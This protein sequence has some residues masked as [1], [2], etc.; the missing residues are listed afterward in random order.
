M[1]GWGCACAGGLGLLVAGGLVAVAGGLQ[2]GW[3]VVSGPSAGKAWHLASKIALSSIVAAAGACL[4][5]HLCLLTQLL[6]D[7]LI[8]T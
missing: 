2:P 7:V 6:M 1:V 3:T 5:L 4:A 8:G